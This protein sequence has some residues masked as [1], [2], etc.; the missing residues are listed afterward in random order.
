MGEWINRLLWEQQIHLITTVCV[1][2]QEDITFSLPG[3]RD[4]SPEKAVPRVFF[5]FLQLMEIETMSSR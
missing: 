3:P 4:S 1:D 2:L 5:M